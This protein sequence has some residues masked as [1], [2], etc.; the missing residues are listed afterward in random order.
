MGRLGIIAGGGELPLIGMKEALSQGEDPIFLSVIESEFQFGAF[1]ER[2]IPIHIGQ[3][4]RLLKLCKQNSIDR[5]LLLGKVK[6]EILFKNLKVDLKGISLLAKMYNRHDYS[7]FKTVADEFLKE[8]IEIISQKKYLQTLLLPEGRY[9]K[10]KLTKDELA[11]VEFGM[12]YAEAMASMDVGQTVVVLD[13]V[14]LS[15][16]AVEGT[17]AAIIRGG[18][19]AKAKVRAC[20]CKSS[21]PGQDDRFDLP[22]AGIGT[23]EIMKKNNCGT[24]AIRTGETIIVNPGEFIKTAE[25]YKIHILSIGDGDLKKTNAAYKKI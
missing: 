21:K 25:K 15:V 18:S 10:K 22:T 19:F 1:P 17:D 8:G 13:R 24:L 12:K 11:D 5:L 3:I 9:T 2:E 20:V 7:I 6:K 14:V 16:E 4:G 23:L